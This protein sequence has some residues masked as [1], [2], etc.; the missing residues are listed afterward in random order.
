MSEPELLMVQV[1]DAYGHVESEPFV[2]RLQAGWAHLE[3][4]GKSLM[5]D[6]E[7]LRAALEPRRE[8]RAA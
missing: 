8:V 5:V 1:T 7:E 4:E 6:A 3:F 2:V